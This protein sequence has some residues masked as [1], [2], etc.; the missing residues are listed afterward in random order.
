MR[1]LIISDIHGNDVG[2]K[3]VLEDAG[4]VDK[5]ICAGDITGYYPFINEVI[6]ILKKHGA[7]SVV[8]NH[9]KYLLDGAA[10]Q[11][12]DQTI[13]A[14]VRRMEKIITRENLEFLRGLSNPLELSIDGRSILLCHASPWDPFE[15]RIYPDS[16]EFFRFLSLPYDVV[17]Y[18]HTHYPVIKQ[19]GS[20]QIVNPGSCGQPRDYN[21][22]SYVIWDTYTNAFENKRIPWDITAFQKKALRAGAPKELFHVFERKSDRRCDR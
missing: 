14:S 19:F 4:T 22:L 13:G 12:A 9:D 18:G 5:I 17:I 16:K 21:L 11:H 20:M 8:G 6:G 10:P 7:V 2:L 1:V 3:T 15:E